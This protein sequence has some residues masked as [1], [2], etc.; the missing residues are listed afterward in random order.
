[1]VEI[2]IKVGETFKKGKD[3]HRIDLSMRKELGD[4]SIDNIEGNFYEGFLILKNEVKELK[5]NILK[6]A[7]I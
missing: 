7:R 4:R 2:T 6:D 5:E 1:M 3:F